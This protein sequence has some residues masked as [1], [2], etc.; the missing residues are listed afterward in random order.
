MNGSPEHV[1]RIERLERLL[2]RQV[3]EPGEPYPCPYLPRRLARQV[4]LGLP[5]HHPGLYHALMDLNFRRLGPI[6]YRPACGACQACRTLRVPVAEF[7]PDRSQRR[8]LAKNADLEVRVGVPEPSA[9][10]HALYSRYLAERHDGQMSGAWVEF[11]GFL[12]ASPIDTLELQFRKDGRLLAVCIADL[13]P[14]ALSAVYCFY[15]PREARRALGVF[16]VLRLIEECQRRGLPHLYLGYH[17][18]DAP[19]MTYKADYVPCELLTADGRWQRLERRR[20]SAAS[21]HQGFE[22]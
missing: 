18:A 15:E 22:R 20:R 13:E 17:V 16:N 9:E 7:R 6:V 21:G 1:Q 5:G 10:K 4:S 2:S 8:C 19:S 11:L 3:L 12:Y 14:A